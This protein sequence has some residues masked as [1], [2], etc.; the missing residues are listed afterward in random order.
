MRFF[1]AVVG[2]SLASAPISSFADFVDGNQLLRLC[3]LQTP[4]TTENVYC[5]GYISGMTDAIRGA[6]LSLAP[7]DRTVCVPE[8]VEAQQAL[9]VIVKFMDQHPEI[10]NLGSFAS[11]MAALQI[12]F[13][14]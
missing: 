4:K 6:M 13:P 1:A 9:K 8:N 10:L 11:A 12:A 3:V 2:F 5:L 7:K 14:C